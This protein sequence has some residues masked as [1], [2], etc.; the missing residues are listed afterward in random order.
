MMVAA[1]EW[2]RAQERATELME[3]REEQ[4]VGG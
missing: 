1:V 2:W 3:R 4:G